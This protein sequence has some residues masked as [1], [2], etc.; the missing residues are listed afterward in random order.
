MM[1]SQLLYESIAH[2]DWEIGE[3]ADEGR[4]HFAHPTRTD[5]FW[6]GEPDPIVGPHQIEC[7]ACR[8]L[9]HQFGSA[10]WWENQ[11]HYE[12]VRKAQ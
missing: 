4:S 12:K 2:L 8:A 5:V 1:M 9:F 7:E 3:D 10:W 6:C 11:T